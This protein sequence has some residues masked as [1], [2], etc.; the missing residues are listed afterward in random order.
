MQVITILYCF[1]VEGLTI[2]TLI[3]MAMLVRQ[4]SAILIRVVVTGFL[5]DC[6]VLPLLTKK[7]S[8]LLRTIFRARVSQKS[9]R[10]LLVVF[11]FV[12][13]PDAAAAAWKRATQM[14]L[15]LLIYCSKSG[16]KSVCKIL[17][18]IR[19]KQLQQQHLKI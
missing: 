16:T 17:L 5:W 7:K 13:I 14:L 12:T 2:N 4:R 15:Q 6:L 19:H 1:H 3:N 18:K 8:W 9:G 10:G 11:F